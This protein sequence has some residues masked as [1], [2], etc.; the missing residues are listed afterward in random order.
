MYLIIPLILISASL[1]GIGF[2]VWPKL[3]VLKN[4][5][6][7]YKLESGENF[8]NLMF[9]EFFHLV[10]K[11]DLK[12]YKESFLSDIEKFLRRIKIL[13]LKIDNAINKWLEQRPKVSNGDFNKVE[14]DDKEKT[15]NNIEENSKKATVVNAVF[16]NKEKELIAKISQNPK[17]KELYKALG[18]LYL[19]YN[20]LS[21]AKAVFNVILEL[22]PNDKEAR[23]T[24]KKIK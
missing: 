23:E 14:V 8:W 15:G 17:D 6:E 11:I 3:R 22:D 24:L 9:P 12:S 13:S 2:I 4:S 20:E 21:D 1:F 19:E 18:A 5:S 16:K 7:S 10:D